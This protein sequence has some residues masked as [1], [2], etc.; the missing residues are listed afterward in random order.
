MDINRL[1]TEM[2]LEEKCRMLVGL[3]SWH[4][5]SV[6]RLDIPSIMMADGPH[7][8]RKQLDSTNNMMVNESYKA[9]CFPPA[10]TIA[11]SFDPLMTFK[12][13][14]AIANECLHKDVQVLL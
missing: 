10:V 3:D 8:L 11:A 2:T 13:G 7:G 6:P 14:E 1:L 12:M 5:I 9:V 4:T